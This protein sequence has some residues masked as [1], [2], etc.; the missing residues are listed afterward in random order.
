MKKLILFAVV[1]GSTIL[2]AGCGLTK[3][4]AQQVEDAVK[5]KVEEKVNEA[6][7]EIQD[8]TEQKAE[9]I[10]N[11][12]MGGKAQKCTLK[13]P[14]EAVQAEFYTDGKGKMY[15]SYSIKDDSGKER[16]TKMISDGKKIYGWDATTK[17]GTVITEKVDEMEDS[18]MM[19]DDGETAEELP[20]DKAL[21]TSLMGYSCTNWTVN[22]N[23][24]VPPKDVQ[25]TDIDAMMEQAKQKMGQYS[26]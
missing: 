15:M 8:R 14:D 18:A 21:E 23:K 20:E 1:V 22:P 7:N 16:V 13:G 3:S 4:P 25:F 11:A 24:F 6:K 12:I 5:N 2:L 10:K 9:N 19:G 17:K 26:Y